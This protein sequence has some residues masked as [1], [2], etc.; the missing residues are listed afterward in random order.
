ML[1]EA[2]KNNS[3]RINIKL[4]EHK[5]GLVRKCGA[6]GDKTVHK[7]LYIFLQQNRPK[8]W[9]RVLR[10]RSPQYRPQGG[11]KGTNPC[12]SPLG[13]QRLI[14]LEQDNKHCCPLGTGKTSASGEGA[15]L[16]LGNRVPDGSDGKESACNVGDLGL[17]PGLGQSPGEGHNNPLQYSC[18][19]NSMD[20]GAWQATVHGVAKSQTRLSD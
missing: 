20:R 11:G 12:L 4:V 1:L 9:M 19:K 13:N 5:Y 2:I 7:L 18:L 17:I 8:R 16:Q 14:C 10:K 15:G 6:C 3:A